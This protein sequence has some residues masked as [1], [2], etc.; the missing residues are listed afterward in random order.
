VALV[1]EIGRRRGADVDRRTWTV[2]RDRD[3]PVA[4]EQARDAYRSRRDERT[5]R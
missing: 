1:Y 4:A 2:R 3:E 5:N